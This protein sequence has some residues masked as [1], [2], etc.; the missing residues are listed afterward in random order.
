[1]SRVG[2]FFGKLFSGH[3]SP[4][5]VILRA[6]G[7]LPLYAEYRRLE[8]SPG[9]PTMFSQWLDEGRLAWMRSSEDNAKGTTLATR[10]VLHWSVSRE[11]LI[12]NIW[13]S[14]DSLGRVFPF[15]FFIVCSPESLGNTLLERWTSCVAIHEFFD[16]A[17]AQL[18]RVGTGG[19]FYR[20]YRQRAVPTQPPD[21]QA[22]VH[23]LIG[24]GA[25]DHA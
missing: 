12:A 1:M 22:E 17:H 11:W 13:D 6:Y 18:A 7:K 15:A 4:G 16:Q 20:L 2:Q 14:R 3:S 25:S 10:V 9:L 5:E 21:Y 23:Q 19:D 24:P 8:V